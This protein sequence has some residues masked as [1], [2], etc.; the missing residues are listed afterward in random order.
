MRRSLRIAMVAPPWYRVPPSG[1]GGV[2]LVCAALVDALVA[3]GHRVTLFGTGPDSGTAARFVGTAR[4][5]QYRR[6]GEDMMPMLMH[7]ARVNRHLA[8]GHFDVIH[9][10]TVA[11]ALSA[12]GRSA[13]TVVTMH[14][15]PVRPVLPT[16][17]P[18]GHPS[19]TVLHGSGIVDQRLAAMC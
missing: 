11:G 4:T 10:H 18:A 17:P 12:T 3:H 1:Y 13:P 9:D 19:A 14:G 16:C 15:P 8:A 2:E 5:L 7:V 6:M